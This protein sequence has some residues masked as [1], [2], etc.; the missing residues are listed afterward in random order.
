MKL[1]RS[2]NTKRNII[3]GMINRLVK[4]IL[5]F[6]VRTIMIQKLG[7]EY[8]GLNSLFSSILQVLNMAELGFGSALVYSMYQ[9]IAENDNDTIC[10]LLKFYRSVYRIIG[11]VIFAAGLMLLPFIPRMINGSCPENINIYVLFCI[12]LINTVLSYWLFAYK[13]ALLNAYQRIDVI[14]NIDTVVGL[15]LNLLQIIVLCLFCNYYLFLV[16]MPMCTCMD[17]I[18]SAYCVKR[19]FPQY[20]CKGNLDKSMK[21]QI[22]IKVAGLMINKVCQISRNAFDSIVISSFLGLSIS[23]IYSNYYYVMIV[24]VTLEGVVTSSMLAGVG[25]SVA[26]ETTEK[27]YKDLKKIDFIYMWLSGWCTICFLCLIQPFMKYWMG[28][29]LMFPLSVAILLAVYFYML[30]VGDVRA[31]YSEAAGLWWEHR[32][33]AIVEAITNIILNYLLGKYL[34]INGIILATILSLCIISHGFGT[35]IVFDYY[36]KN[37]KK[38]EYYLLH[39]RYT[40]VTA[41]ICGVTFWLCHFIIIEGIFGLVLKFLLCCIFPNMLYLAIYYS[42]KEFHESV[43]W[44][45]KI[46]HLKNRRAKFICRQDKNR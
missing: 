20:V 38:M 12:Y 29:E 33:R 40:L 9:A 26:S 34:G 35:Q 16:L 28:E 42:T 1:P 44:L 21:K 43:P 39:V 13:K 31:M 14:Y 25:N 17:N 7:V 10:A 32:Y 11:A 36:F 18:I 15:L 27:N 22:K 45:C 8:L 37:G 19:I 3:Y 30:K 5:P 46:L 4:L 24:A 6:I 41:G 2:E 23:A